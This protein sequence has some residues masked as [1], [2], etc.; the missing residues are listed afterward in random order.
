[1]NLLK[2]KEKI[3]D[4]NYN[5]KVKEQRK[6]KMNNNMNEKRKYIIEVKAWLN[7]SEVILIINIY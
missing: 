6:S 4:N 7:Y 3:K 1:M 5:N 2:E